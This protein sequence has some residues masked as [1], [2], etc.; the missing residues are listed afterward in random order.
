MCDEKGIVFKKVQFPSLKSLTLSIN[1]YKKKI[2]RRQPKLLI[3][4]VKI[5]G[6]NCRY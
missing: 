1:N 4:Y 3:F 2:T 5:G 6:K